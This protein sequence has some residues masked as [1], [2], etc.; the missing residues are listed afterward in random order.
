ML[1]TTKRSLKGAPP[2]SRARVL[3]RQAARTTAGILLIFALGAS[4]SGCGATG[5]GPVAKDAT[6]RHHTG[7]PGL[8][9]SGTVSALGV[10]RR[11]GAKVFSVLE[12]RRTE[13]DRLPSVRGGRRGAVSDGA[14][15]DRTRWLAAGVWLVPAGSELC[16]VYLVRALTAAPSGGRLPPAI[17]Q[18]CATVVHAAAGQLVASQSLSPSS[19]AV[20]GATRVLGLVP[21]GVRTV[22][23]FDANGGTT[24]VRVRRNFYAGSVAEP[25]AVR[26]SRRV[27]NTV[28]I[29]RIPIASFDSRAARPA[30]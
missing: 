18:Q 27:G 8:T 17:V 21:D 24:E 2:I 13:R 15:A 19:H 16:L 23:I 3:H 25:T 22:T 26:F 11:S 20:P 28:L 6:K 5:S 1:L 9:S 7:T 30:R 14:D 12:T 29:R 4:M 10:G